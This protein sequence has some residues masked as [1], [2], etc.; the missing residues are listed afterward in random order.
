M[1]MKDNFCGFTYYIILA[2]HN[3]CHSVLSYYKILIHCLWIGP[4]VSVTLLYY[5]ISPSVGLLGTTGRYSHI[6]D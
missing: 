3:F 6:L 2:H 5:W 1:I 4:L